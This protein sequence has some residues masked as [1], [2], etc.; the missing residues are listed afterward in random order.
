MKSLAFGADD[1]REA[2]I[3]GSPCHEPP[4]AVRGDPPPP[5]SPPASSARRRAVKAGGSFRSTPARRERG[6]HGLD[7]PPA[8]TAALSLALRCGAAA[9]LALASYKL[10][11]H[12][13]SSSCTLLLNLLRTWCLSKELCLLHVHLGGCRSYPLPIHSAGARDGC[14]STV[15]G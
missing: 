4:A 13:L 10:R 15:H 14:S 12:F 3:P 11:A 6:W 1:A 2:G 9:E 8:K 7:S 5:V